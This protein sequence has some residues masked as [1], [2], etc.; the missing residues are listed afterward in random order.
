[1]VLL[2]MAEIP[3]NQLRLVVEIPLFIGFQHHARWLGMRFQPSTVPS[4]QCPHDLA[5]L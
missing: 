4:L 2:L 3:N 1:M 5:K